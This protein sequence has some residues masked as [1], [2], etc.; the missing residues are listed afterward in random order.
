MSQKKGQNYRPCLNKLLILSAS[1]STVMW[2]D[3]PFIQ[4]VKKDCAQLPATFWK[5]MLK[6]MYFL[7]LDRM[8]FD[9]LHNPFY[10]MPGV[11]INKSFESCII[12]FTV[13]SYTHSSVLPFVWG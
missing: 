2:Q 1:V 10:T 6:K 13:C 5:Q 12:V 3:P 11:C 4:T 9:S 8:R 7:L